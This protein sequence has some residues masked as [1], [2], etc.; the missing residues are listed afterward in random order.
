M[1]RLATIASMVVLATTL[2]PGMSTAQQPESPQPYV[3]G[4]PLGL[5]VT[6]SPAA[7]F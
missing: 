4:N 1:T 6:P 2:I 5:P 7:S 3:V